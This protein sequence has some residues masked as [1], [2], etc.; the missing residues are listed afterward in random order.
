MEGAWT[1][2]PTQW[3]INFLQ[4]LFAYN[5]VKTK[6]PAG[7]IQWIPDAKSAANL[8]PDAHIAGKRHVP[9]MLTTDLSLRFD[10]AYEKISRRFLEDPK[11]F[12]LAFAK[13]WFKLMHRDMGP[14]A[15]Y[16]GAEV[17]DETLI[18]QDAVPAVNYELVNKSDIARLKSKILG[19]KLS[20]SELVRTA[21]ASA[22]SYRGTDMRGGANEAGHKVT[23]PFTPGRT[24]A[25]QAQTDTASF[26]KLEP[27][28][29]G[30]RN[31]FATATVTHQRIC[32]L[33]KRAC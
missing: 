22:S 12:E 16:V 21:W 31:Y 17:P 33:I 25:S 13:A 5:W 8:V 18:W 23:V 14:R 15:R 19:T 26:A 20:T 2:T 6:S 24:D 29:D 28:A 10:P 30:F 11:E 27:S 9:V 32:W 4:N 7:A 1:T 3:S